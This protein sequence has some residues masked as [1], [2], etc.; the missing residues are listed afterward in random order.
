MEGSQIIMQQIL[1]PMQRN[2]IWTVVFIGLF[3]S[4]VNVITDD[5]INSDGIL[6]SEVA[7]KLLN[8]DW[9][10][11]LAQF[12]WPFYP[13]LV[14]AI[15]KIIFLDFELTAQLV[16]AGLLALLAYMFIRCS[17]LMGGD[18]LVIIAAGVLLLTNVTLNG[19]RDLIIRD[20][21][22]W[23]MFF[24]AVYF[25]LQYHHS[26]ATKHALGFGISILIATMFR[27]E[28]IVFAVL[29]P[30]IFLF[31]KESWHVRWRRYLTPMLPLMAVGLAGL[32]AILSVPEL[33]NKII[34][35]TQFEG[36]LLGPL[37]YFQANILGITQGIIEK[38]NL[39]EEHVFEIHSRKL[40]TQSMV[41]ILIMLLI[42]KIISAT[43]YLALLFSILASFSKKLRQSILGLDVI[44][45]FLLINLLVLIVVVTSKTFLTPRYAMTFA[46]LVTL[47]AA[48][49]LADFF[50]VSVVQPSV[51]KKRAK[52]FLIVI[53]SYMFLDG[54][55]STGASKKYL[56][57]SGQWLKENAPAEARLFA[58]EESA[59]YYS[60]RDVDRNILLFAFNETRFSRLPPI[61]EALRYDYVSM[62][63]SAKQKGFERKVIDWVGSQPIYRTAN[64]R[65]DAVLIFKV[66]K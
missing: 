46:L 61:G 16:N 22:Y 60:G 9:Q 32:L 21:G 33:Q 23:A 58:N 57:E 43:G 45:G 30:T 6:Y 15:S 18:K 14:G 28:G 38:G 40:G 66:S 34:S 56:R 8:G 62:K 51:W 64:K 12:T 35:A 50:R 11:A 53:F 65:G 63:V 3:I 13:L 4:F 47:P 41:A 37:N 42:V 31:H 54:L 1:R 10:A 49:A 59:Y 2:P 27:I 44:A 19:Y 25:F 5:V 24:T 55:I 26:K 39:I 36:E 20:H 7:N 17:Q 48:F 52:V 29:A